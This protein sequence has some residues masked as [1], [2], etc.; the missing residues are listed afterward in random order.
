MDLPENYLQSFV[1]FRLCNNY[2]PIEKGRWLG[3]YRNER[4]CHLCNM[5]DVG[6]E[7]HYMLKCTY[8]DRDRNSLLSFVNFN[9]CNIHTFKSIMCEK[10]IDKLV[11]ICK[12][13]KKVL[14]SFNNNHPPGNS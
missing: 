2:L 10:D 14:K 11:S 12:Y 7:Y 6:D 4:K 8:F 9:S 1:N 13:I 5:N 3:L